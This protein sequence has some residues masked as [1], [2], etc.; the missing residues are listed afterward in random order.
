LEFLAR[1]QNIVL[2]THDSENVTNELPVS[3][4]E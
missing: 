4:L 2:Q 3:V 1:K